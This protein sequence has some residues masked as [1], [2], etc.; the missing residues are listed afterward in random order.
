MMY[1]K[2]LGIVAGLGLCLLN[3]CGTQ[4]EPEII[5]EVT[6]NAAEG[7]ETADGGETPEAMAH[8]GAS[9]EADAWEELPEEQRALFRQELLFLQQGFR[10]HDIQGSYTVYFAQPSEWKDQPFQKMLLEGE[11]GLW[12][13]SFTYNYDPE[14]DWYTF[15][16]EYEPVLTKNDSYLAKDDEDAQEFRTVSVYQAEL[17]AEMNLEAPLRFD[18]PSGPVVY[19]DLRI[20]ENADYLD[21][22]IY[23]Y[24]DERMGVT[25]TVEYPQ[26]S[27]YTPGLEDVKKINQC[28]REAFFLWNPEELMHCYL[29]RNCEITR[30]D[31][32]YLSACIYADNTFHYA[33]HPS[34]WKY[35][36]TI[37][38]TTG[39]ALTLRDVIG[40]DRTVQ[41]LTGT[42][43]FHSFP[44]WM[45]GYMSPEEMEE[46]DRR[47]VEEASQWVDVDATDDFYLT[48]DKLGLTSSVSR[49]YVCMEA[50]F[51]EIG[52]TEWEAF[53]E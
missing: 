51:A 9:E 15:S 52:L 49:Y 23:V 47:Q 14:R 22:Y 41:E 12:Y 38:L 16:G 1:K 53:S 25:V 48:P 28:I 35:G 37:D 43:A 30:R 34:T 26:Y 50:P 45:D 18:I 7:T 32:S 21:M 39:Q 13:E 42:G 19:E 33:A 3:G 8:A 44:I 11:E 24:K 27:V 29:Y 4:P 2:I 20:D 10:Q 40:P 31:D 5:S 6:E 36:M 46:A 17:S